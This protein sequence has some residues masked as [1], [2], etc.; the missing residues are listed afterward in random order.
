MSRTNLTPRSRPAGQAMVIL[1]GAMIAIIAMVG[2]IVD[3]GNA[4]AQQRIVQ[5]GSDAAAEAGAVVLGQRLAGANPPITGWDAAVQ[6]AVTNTA[7]A[8]GIV[9]TAAYYTD[10]CGIPL[11]T[12]GSAALSGGKY[13]LSVAAVVGSGIPASSATTPDCPTLTVGPPAGVLVLGHKDVRTYLANVVGLSSIGVST[14]STAA[15]G[16]LQDACAASQ[17]DACSLLPVTVPVNIV[18]CG[19]SNQPIFPGGAYAADGV[20]VYKVPLCNN[21]PGNVGWLDWTPPSGG[22]SELISSI[23]TP[24]NPA[25][26]LPSWQYVTS[27]GNVNSAG[28]ESAIRA[29]DGQIVLIPQFDLTCGP[30]PNNNP[31][32][33]LVSD[34]SQHFGCLS[35]A[36]NDI[37]GAGQNQWYRIPSLA[38]FQLCISTDAACMAVGAP[39]GA[40]V[41]GNNSSVCDTGNGATSCLVGKFVS[42]ESSGTIGAGFG[43]GTGNSKA[44]GIQ[45]IK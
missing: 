7:T 19:N 34:S 21:D 18:S 12:D 38:H 29:Y 43:G 6:S 22:T 42:I 35:A 23:Q 27:T 45:L 16:Y 40:Y 30:G 32:Q 9:L 5:N 14:Q 39:F 31:S 41:N 3:G 25:I 17:G 8:N 26:S 10:I 33:A 15:S 36:T 2:L 11:Q 28:V 24:N 20:T 37:G 44:I 13:D 4:W 1:V